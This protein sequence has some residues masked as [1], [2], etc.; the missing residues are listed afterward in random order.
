METH[1]EADE[2]ERKHDGIHLHTDQSSEAGIDSL[3]SGDHEAGSIQEFMTQLQ[4]GDSVAA[5]Q[6]FDE[7]S[8]RLLRIASQNISKALRKRFDNDDVV[9]SV[10]RTFFRRQA[11][12]RVRIQHEQQLWQL[13][14]KITICKSRSYARKHTAEKRDATADQSPPGG[15]EQI[16]KQATAE[17][18]VS[19]TEEIGK[20]LQDLPEHS[21]EILYLCLQ[22]ENKSDIAQKMDM[23]R[24]TVHR[25]LKVIY[26]RLSSQFDLVLSVGD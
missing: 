21:G 8:E 20:A 2:V 23:S 5:Q 10:F 7:Y 9:Q 3:S 18:L 17:D 25:T 15:L 22:G 14:V 4:N 24:Q 19:L 26:D 11:D 13:L 1:M 6:I 12:G 16:E